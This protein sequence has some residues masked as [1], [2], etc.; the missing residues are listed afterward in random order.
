MIFESRGFALAFK[1]HKVSLAVHLWG[2]PPIIEKIPTKNKN[3]FKEQ[4]LSFHLSKTYSPGEYNVFLCHG[5]RR[6][7]NYHQNTHS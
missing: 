3:Y 6:W 1:N 2:L 7:L 4:A 5:Y